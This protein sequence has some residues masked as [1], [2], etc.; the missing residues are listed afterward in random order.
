[1]RMR[2]DGHTRWDVR[3]PVGIFFGSPV[4]AD[5]MRSLPLRVEKLE[6]GRVRLRCFFPMA[7]WDKAEIEWANPSPHRFGPIKARVSVGRNEASK[8]AG[9][10]FTTLYHAGE[11]VYGQDWLLFEGTGTGWLAGIVQSMR[12]EHYCEGNERFTIDGA[13]SP[14]IN[15]TGSEDYYLACFWPNPDFDTPFGCVIGN[16]LEKGGGSFAGAYRVPSAYSRFHLEAPIPFY[17]S[18]RAVIQHGGMSD[19]RSEYRSLAFVY[20]RRQPALV[21]TDTIDVGSPISENAHAYRFDGKAPATALTAFSE[22]E[23]FETAL[24]S[25]GRVHVG[26]EISFRAAI[27]PDNNGVRLRRRIDQAVVGR[28]ARVF[29]DGRPAGVWRRGYENPHLRWYD[30]DFD[31]PSEFTRGR[32]HLDVKIVL[33]SGPG[34]AKFTDFGW[35]VYCF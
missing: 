29:I 15:G 23:N 2:W 30:S 5:E 27:R 18:L 20:L 13:V 6:N 26:G 1:M 14:Q 7:F 33:G 22:G 9:T 16:I 25:T 11:T 24:R 32:D 19:I 34:S 8:D 35:R 31:I 4:E 17:C 21:E 3:A 12:N 10:Y 28:E